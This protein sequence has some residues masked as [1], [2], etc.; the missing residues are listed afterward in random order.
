VRIARP[1]NWFKNVFVVPGAVVAAEFVRI[2]PSAWGGRLILALAATCMVASANYVINEWLDRDF[3]RHHPEKR[4]RPASTLT[5][6]WRLVAAEYAVLAA[7]G[8][9]LSAL[10]SSRVLASAVALLAMGLVYNVEPLRSKERAYVD[11]LTE[12]V[13]NPIRLM[14]GW[15]AV[16]DWPLPPSSLLISYWMG[17]AYLMAIKRYSEYRFIGNPETAAR[18]RKSFQHYTEDKLLI[19]ALL[20]ALLAASLG[21]VFL[22]KYRVELVIAI[23][24]V[25]ILFVWYFA[26]GLKPNSP[27]RQPEK[28]W[29]E[30]GFAVYV[31]FVGALLLLCMTVRVPGLNWLLQGAFPVQ[32]G[33]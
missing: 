31:L 28:M 4:N 25:A 24:F 21:S 5:L 15:F 3:D 20:Y 23:P 32:G 9:G 12:S 18:Y 7:V 8:L 29:T 16:T 6:S 2:G 13:N 11:V 22:V 33:R 17:G 10:V 30:K 26:L 19:S 27:T 1:D 14:I